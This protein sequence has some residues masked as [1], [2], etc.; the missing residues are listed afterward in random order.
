MRSTAER[1]N[2]SSPCSIEAD[3]IMDTAPPHDY[4]LAS[5][6]PAPTLSSTSQLF[7]WFLPNYEAPENV[8]LADKIMQALTVPL[9]YSPF[10]PFHPAGHSL[11]LLIFV[12]S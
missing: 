11:T 7:K 1:K 2:G 3:K 4:Q 9:L 5:H 12:I 6:G 8:D 10:Y